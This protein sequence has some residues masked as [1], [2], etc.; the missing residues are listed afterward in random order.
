MKTQNKKTDGKTS[1]SHW[2]KWRQNKPSIESRCKV[3]SNK[4]GEC[5]YSKNLKVVFAL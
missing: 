4:L 3:I 2:L 5:N 1:T